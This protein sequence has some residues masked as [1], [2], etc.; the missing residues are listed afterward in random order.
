MPA[1]DTAD[2]ARIFSGLSVEEQSILDAADAF[3]RKELHPLASRMDDEEWWPPQAF[4]L[5]GTNGFL[6]VTAPARLG[7]A[8]MDLFA[9]GLVLQAFARWNHAL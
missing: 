8:G 6:G 5:I 7:G 3:A 2:T 1:T 9:S 4:P